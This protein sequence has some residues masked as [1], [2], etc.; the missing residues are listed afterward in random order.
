ME[1]PMDRF[2][3]I[4]TSGPQNFHNIS[5]ESGENVLFALSFSRNLIISPHTLPNIHINRLNEKKHFLRF[6][7]IVEDLLNNLAERSSL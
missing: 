3:R 1:N 7:H 6:Y 2:G 5:Q 4:N